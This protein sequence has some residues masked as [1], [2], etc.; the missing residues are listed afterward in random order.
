MASS[1]TPR[2][3]KWSI[4]GLVLLAIAGVAI[5]AAES[6]D[7]RSSSADYAPVSNLLRPGAMP[8]SGPGGATA[9]VSSGATIAQEG[10]D[11]VQE[12]ST[13]KIVQTGEISIEVD[14]GAFD[15]VWR[16]ASAVA[17]TV[18][19]RVMSSN[20]GSEGAEG[21]SVGGQMVLR[22]PARRFDEAMQALRKLGTTLRDATNA[23]DVTE[24]Y[25]DLQSRLRNLRAE[26]RTLIKLF[27]DAD[28]VRDTLA[29][30]ERLSTV[31][32]ELER[33]TGRI[34]F[35]DDRADFSRISVT[36]G[37][38]GTMI[39]QRFSDDPSFS[40]AWDTAWEGLLRIATGSMIAAIWA[41]PFVVLFALYMVIRRRV[42]R[43]DTAEAAA[44][45]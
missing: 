23:E 1:R 26:Q 27:D 25:V 30:Q 32:G 2:L 3:L 20:R 28:S 15:R 41:L 39:A 42:R 21:E 7:G 31:E 36:V 37:E 9:G 40:D 38:V 13:D 33:V 19:G 6:R 43:D 34:K 35:L 10:D 17:A 29:I 24:E 45:V 5:G 22:V 11:E 4:L 16:D 12:P 8:L 44:E 18:G 14:G